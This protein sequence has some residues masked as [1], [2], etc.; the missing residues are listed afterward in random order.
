MSVTPAILAGSIRLPRLTPGLPSIRKELTVKVYSPGETVARVVKAYRQ[1]RDWIYLPRTYGAEL[2]ERW[3]LSVEDH[4][5]RGAKLR[6]LPA[7]DLWPEQVTPVEKMM[8]ATKYDFDFQVKSV[9]GSGKTVM[10]LEVARRLGR[11]TL[12]VVDTN[13]LRDQWVERIEEHFSIPADEVGCIQGKTI[14]IGKN[15]FTVG[16]MQTLYN[17]KLPTDIRR[18]FGTVIFDECHGTGAPEFNRVLYRFPAQVRFGV[19]AV[20]RPGVL[21]K[22]I[23]WHIGDV[24]IKT[25][26]RHRESKV[27]YLESDSIYSWYA[28]ISPKTGRFINE[29]AGDGERN[30]KL[31]E[32]IKW[33]YEHERDA[34]IISDRIEQLEGLMALCSFMGIPE[35]AMGQCTA[36]YH[37]YKY[38][39]E[40]KPPRKPKFLEKGCEYT[41]VAL[42]MVKKRSSKA[43]LEEGKQRQLIFATFSIFAKGVD[44]PR[45]N[46][47][48]DCTPRSS[49]ENTHGRILRSGKGKKV[50]IWITVRDVSS[51]RAEYQFA[52]RLKELT[53][54]NV[55]VFRWRPN[56]GVQNRNAKALVQ[57]AN[58]NCKRL[59]LLKTGTM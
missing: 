56:K 10:A 41:P 27:Y 33:I 50:P 35:E 14:D 47:G 46:T 16:M 8:L 54:S 39:K 7:I 51:Y 30:L 24:Q 44:V 15:G 17:K 21:G 29:I 32:V 31:A 4:T 48:L 45:L 49:F 28:N 25:T 1:N 42:Q 26:T 58:D 11:T 36:H 43:K 37:V 38:A 52:I 9:T 13:F 20:P 12:I 55:E 57:E 34:L 40:L 18:Y 59:K 6:S 19:T 23:R 5:S 3:G 22:V 2:C 53:K